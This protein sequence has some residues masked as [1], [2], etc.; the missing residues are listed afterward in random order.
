MA[1][2]EQSTKIT[3]SVHKRLHA[4]QAEEF[5]LLKERFRENPEAFWRHNKR[6]SREWSVEQFKQALDE[7]EL[8]PV[9]DP[10]NPTS[11]HRIAKATII[12]SL[13]TKYPQDMDHRNSLKRILRIADIDSDGLMQAQTAAPPPDPRMEA[14][15]AKA[16]AEQMKAQIDQAKVQIQA[17]T[18]QANFQDKEKER[19]FKQQMQQMELHLEQ[20]RVQ[21]EMII[22]AKDMQRDD[23]TAQNDMAAKQAETAH[24]LI[25][26]HASKQ[27]DLQQAAQKHQ[28]EIAAN[29]HKHGQEIEAQR[30]KHQQTMAA[31][32][33][34]HAQQVQLE[35]EKHQASLENQKTI[36]EAKAEAI[37]PAEQARSGREGEK[38]DQQMKIDQE[39]HE[40]KGEKH[41][42]DL[43][44]SKKNGGGQDQTDEQAEAETAGGQ[45]M[46]SLAI[47]IL[48]LAIGIIVVC[49]CIWLLLYAIKL[50][51]EIPGRIEQLVWVI[52]LILC[53]IYALTLL[54]GEERRIPFI[55][56]GSQIDDLPIPPG[57][58]PICNTC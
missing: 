42:V 29:A 14:I 13:V 34:Q 12:D 7:R 22:H 32:R 49:G 41:K 54:S 10:N 23:A 52:I 9:A 58:P 48:W 25:A 26:D 5:G 51:I 44:T 57:P 6:P 39:T 37:G 33:E 50:F 18:A 36:A 40:M 55:S 31:Q 11:L 17:A 15:K 21:A 24:G 28:L 45:V 1:M 53:L 19:A 20:L 46:V 56:R 38:H 4:A 35:R 30:Q 47:S 27:A 43:E 2:I 16:Q 8:V 3:D